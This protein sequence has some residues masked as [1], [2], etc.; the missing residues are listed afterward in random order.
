MPKR[1]RSF[2]LKPSLY[3]VNSVNSV[4]SVKRG[5]IFISDGIFIIINNENH[6]VVIQTQ[7]G[8]KH[9]RVNKFPSQMRITSD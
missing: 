9:L 5:A 2:S 4:D 7:A 1:K 8:I 6:L 3:S